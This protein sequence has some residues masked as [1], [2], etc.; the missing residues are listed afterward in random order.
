LYGLGQS[1]LTDPY[2]TANQ[3]MNYGVGIENS[4]ANVMAQGLNNGI[5]VG[6]LGN[7]TAIA[8]S[9]IN[10]QNYLN[11]LYNQRANDATWTSVGNAIGNINW[12][13]LFSGGLPSTEGVQAYQ[14]GQSSYVDPTLYGGVRIPGLSY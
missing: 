13:G 4:G 8:N 3:I 1:Y 14:L 6:Q 12:G 10:Q 7:Q 9:N 2:N 5:N 11:S